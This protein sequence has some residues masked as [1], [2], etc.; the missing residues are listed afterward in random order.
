M[1]EKSS[2]YRFMSYSY[3]TA[4]RQ[5]MDTGNASFS[6][7]TTKYPGQQLDMRQLLIWFHLCQ[8][9]AFMY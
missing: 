5:L 2:T 4:T 8:A 1:P 6:L 3:T 7:E 9:E